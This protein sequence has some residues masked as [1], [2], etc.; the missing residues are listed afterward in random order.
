MNIKTF[1]KKVEFECAQEIIKR[2]Q[3]EFQVDLGNEVYYLTQ[4]LISS[5]R[6]LIDDPK[7]DY[8]Y[9]NEIEKILIKIK[10]ETKIDLSDDKQLINA[11]ECRTS[12]NAVRYEYS[13]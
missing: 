8:E 4:H 11:L 3:Q 6:F 13:K 10:E 5:Q 1:E 2:I 7:E 12:E 9:K